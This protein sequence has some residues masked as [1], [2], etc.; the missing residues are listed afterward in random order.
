M[1]CSLFL[2]FRWDPAAA[3]MTTCFLSTSLS[4]ALGARYIWGDRGTAGLRPVGAQWI[5]GDGSVLTA[6]GL[7]LL[8]FQAARRVLPPLPAAALG[9]ASTALLNFAVQD[10]LVFRKGAQS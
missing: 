9:I 5:A 4:F 7:N 3:N 1:A 6:A 8:V 10:R 2:A